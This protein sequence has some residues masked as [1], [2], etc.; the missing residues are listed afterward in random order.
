MLVL[1]LVQSILLKLGQTMLIDTNIFL[2]AALAQERQQESIDFLDA[3]EHQ[4]LPY[5][6][7]ISRFTL[8]ALEA[9]LNERA[10]PFLLHI[11]LLIQQEKIQ[12][13]DLKP[14]E[15]LMVLALTKEFGLDFD[16]MVQ[17]ATA[18]HLDVPV[19][20]YDR[21][22]QNKEIAVLSPKQLLNHSLT[23]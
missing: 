19:I 9:M 14:N 10:R 23:P 21:D 7:Y 8:H 2:E 5:Q 6:A 11:L 16:D 3:V 18:S 22:F 20:T 4:I 15:D 12:I 13:V 17:Y 1:G